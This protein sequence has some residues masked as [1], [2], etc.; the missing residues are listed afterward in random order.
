MERQ[1]YGAEGGKIFRKDYMRRFVSALGGINETRDLSGA[2]AVKF[3]ADV[4]LAMTEAS[5]GTAW[6]RNILAHSRKNSPNFMNFIRSCEPK[7]CGGCNQK[8]G[9]SSS[10][11]RRNF[12]S[13]RSSLRRMRRRSCHSDSSRRL[14]NV[15]CRKR[16]KRAFGGFS[17]KKIGENRVDAKIKVLKSLV[18]GGTAMDTPL[19]LHEALEYISALQVQVQ[20]MRTLVSYFENVESK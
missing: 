13:M 18:P 12:L 5:S 14:I 10:E 19:L 6:S 17:K 9:R 3:A 20:S 8:L 4:S 16:V 7:S 11:W 2:R 1:G 15:S